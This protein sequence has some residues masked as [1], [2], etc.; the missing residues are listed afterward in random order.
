MVGY[1]C[2]NVI[3]HGD[4][5]I[6]AGTFL[7]STC[8]K[9]EEW[10]EEHV[11]GGPVFRGRETFRWAEVNAMLFRREDMPDKVYLA[12]RDTS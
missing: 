12:M 5:D 3:Y 10:A 7:L 1:L 8:G 4:R 11:P 6:F 9:Y 2:S